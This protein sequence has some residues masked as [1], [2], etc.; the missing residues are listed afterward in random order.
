MDRPDLIVVDVESTGLDPREHVVIEVAAVNVR[1]GESLYFVPFFHPY[2]KSQASDQAMATNRYYE[3]RVFKDVLSTGE[4]A[5]KYDQ[6]W[7]ML[8]GNTLGGANARFDAEMLRYSN[9]RQTA[10][11]G[12]GGELRDFYFR[13]AD[14]VWKYRLAD[15]GSY[16][17]GAIGNDP[18]EIPSLRE[19]CDYLGVENDSAH[20]ALGDARATAECFRR[21]K[22]KGS[23][24]A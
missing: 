9:A 4:T 5:N 2:D 10:M 8:R 11:R 24:N 14:E 18:N 6:L 7:D 15:L 22:E 12:T 21:L 16:A 3:R 19:V 23:G 20:S 17:Q 1:T 13:P